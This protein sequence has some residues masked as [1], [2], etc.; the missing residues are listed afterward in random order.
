MARFTQYALAASEEALADADWRPVSQ[1]QRE[2][3]VGLSS[4]FRNEWQILT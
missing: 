4:C 3:T 1:K 2:A